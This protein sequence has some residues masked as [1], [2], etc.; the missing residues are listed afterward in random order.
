MFDYLQIVLTGFVGI[1][2]ALAP[3]RKGRVLTRWGYLLVILA[4]S[5]FLIAVVEAH[6]GRME[7]ENAP[8]RFELESS[9]QLTL[10]AEYYAPFVDEA[11]LLQAVPSEIT[12]R[13]A[14]L[15]TLR[16]DFDLAAARDVWFPSRARTTPPARVYFGGTRF[17]LNDLNPRNQ[18]YQFVWDLNNTKLS[19]RI[20]IQ[21]FR[22]LVD[23][24]DWT[25]R[26]TLIVG[27][28]AFRVYAEG[29]GDLVFQLTGLSEA[30]VKG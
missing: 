21:D 18:Q 27:G 24:R 10:E 29:Q 23:N 28:K 14:D 19:F 8:F 11:A 17:R 7:R 2:S 4:A 6:Q 3:L 5:S 15:G 1:L 9:L 20:P 30:E 13:S 12:V 26:G 25:I 16:I 22:R